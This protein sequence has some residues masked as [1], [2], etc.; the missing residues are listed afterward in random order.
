MNVKYQ[1]Y[2]ADN[3]LE[4]LKKRKK[5][6]NLPM[7]E[8]GTTILTGSVNDLE[9]ILYF[10]KLD[11]LEKEKWID[12]VNRAIA[13]GKNKNKGYKKTPESQ[14]SVPQ[15]LKAEGVEI[16]IPV[17]KRGAKVA[18]DFSV[19]GKNTCFLPMVSLVEKLTCKALC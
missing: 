2:M 6:L 10:L 3:H 13:T 14:I 17:A 15:K 12:K 1:K 9:K 11:A 16:D 8:T 7:K 4:V 18:P 19:L 5:N